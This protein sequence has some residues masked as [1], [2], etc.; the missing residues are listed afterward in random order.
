EATAFK[1]HNG[2]FIFGYSDGIIS[3]NP[4]D[5]THDDFKPYI[6]LSGF[7]IFNKNVPIGK[8]S[9]LTSA[10]DYVDKLVLTHKQNFFTV[11]FAALDM[12]EANR[13]LYAYKLEGFDNDWNYIQKQRVANYTNLPHGEYILHVRSTN[14]EGLWMNNERSLPIEILPSF[15]ETPVAYLLYVISV[16]AVGF[17]IFYILITIYHLKANVKFEKQMS[18]MKLRFFTDI[19]HEIRTPL[20]MI[21]APLE[22]I[23]NDT[24]TPDKIRKQLKVISQNTSRLLRLVN[25]I[26]DFRKMQFMKIRVMET[27]IAKAVKQIYENFSEIAKAQHITYQFI[28]EST[29]SLIWVDADCLEKI[30][31]NLLSNAFKYTPQEK[32]ISVIIKSDDKTVSVIVCDQGPGMNKEK[33][34]RLFTRFASFNEDKDK[35]STGIGL[36]MVRDLAEKH[37]A[38]VIVDSEVNRGSCFTVTFLRGINHFNK[39]VEIISGTQPATVS[40]SVNIQQEFVQNESTVSEKH[41]SHKHADTILVVED[42]NDLRKFMRSVLEKE[43]N[44]LEA[45]DGQEGVEKAR[46]YIPDFVV[47]DIMMPR[48]DGI[49]LLKDLK[50]CKDTSHI[51]IV[52][53]TAKTTIESKLEGL[54]YGADDYITKP[55]SVTY[56]M[57]RIANLLEQ[58]RHLQ[59][60]YRNMI[61]GTVN[62]EPSYEPQPFVIAS[63]D[64]EMMKKLVAIIEENMAKPD[65][66]VENIGQEL[67]MSRSVFFRKLKSLTGLSPI[68]FIRDIRMKRAAQLLASGEYRVKEAAAMVGISDTKYFGKCFKAKYGITPQEYKNKND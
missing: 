59:E 46:E 20:T 42:D 30:V 39:K 49:E 68:E 64:E 55:F 45:I 43:Y 35:P 34:R 38:R 21:T 1:T 41:T 17:L 56:F 19:S 6:A 23:L 15:W 63:H 8:K 29:D 7:Q 66:V 13:I 65:F 22:N 27:D 16:L 31:M 67:S 12:T 37:G 58:R 28:N 14:S 26:L 48:M 36:S 47:S 25:Q 3:F 61:S 9:P 18:E 5:I 52:L 60:H 32:T 51:P 33:Q 2:E 50:T 62:E 24:E 40:A 53:L 44:V 10:I 57:A 4:A 54:G 11:S